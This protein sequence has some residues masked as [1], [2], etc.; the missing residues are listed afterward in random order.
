MTSFDKMVAG[1]DGDLEMVVAGEPEESYLLD[2]ITPEDGEA[3]MPKKKEPLAASELELIRTWISQGAVDDTPAGAVLRYDMKHPP[4]Y[5]LPPVITSVDYSP[6]G[7]L[8]AVAGFNEVLLHQADGSAMVARL[9]GMSQRI[10]SVRFSPDGKSLAV[11]GG[12]PAR[13]G[14][15]QVW[16]VDRRKLRLS[17]P[18]GYD[19]VYGASWSP[20]G[21][22][23][24]FG[25]PDN[26]LRAINAKTGK[27]VLYQGSH[28]DWPLDTVFSAA[29]THVISASRDRTAKL[30]EL[31]TQRFIDN[32]TSITPGALSGGLTSVA[33]HPVKDEIL[34]GGADGVPKLFRVFRTSKRVIG[35]DANLIRKF[36]P[37]TGRVFAV[38][39][40]RDG[41]QI[42]AGSSYNGS[43]QV[44]V[45]AY[46]FDGKL[47]KEIEAILGKRATDRSEKEQQQLAEYH[48]KDVKLLAEAEI[49]Q[50]G[51]YAIAFAPDGKTVAAAG[52][53]GKVRLLDAENGALLNAFVP[54]PVDAMQTADADAHPTRPPA[55][56]QDAFEHRSLHAEDKLVSLEVEPA[57]ATIDHKYDVAQLIVT[58]RLESGDL[59]DVTRLVAV[60]VSTD[61]VEVSPRGLAC[62][63]SNGR[64]ELTFSLGG[65]S[66]RATIEVAGVDADA[67][68]DY[69][70]D[71]M[72]VFG[73][74]GCN[75][76]TCHGSKKGKGGLKTSLRGNDPVY[77]IRAFVDDLASRRVNVASAA[78][79]LMLLKAT[80]SVPHEGGQVLRPPDPYYEVIRQWIADGARI[81]TSTPKVA[82]IEIFPKNR[83]MQRT[84][85]QQQFRVVATYADGRVRDVTAEAFI[86]SGD[87]EVAT[88]DSAGLLSAMRRG[89]V[90][91]LARYQGSYAATTLTV[92]GD[93]AG[94]VW[95]DPPAN[96]YV[97]ELVA[98]KLKR[99]KT[100]PSELCT[101]AE[102]IRRVYLDLAGLPPTADQVREFLADERDS[103]T[104]RDELI[105]RLIGCDDYIEH[106]TNRWADLMQVNRKYLGAE[107]AKA[108]RG[109]IR[110][111]V[112]DNTPY[113]RF[114]YKL[115]TASGSNRENPA[116]SY[117]KI[118]RTPEDTM[119]NST[120]LFLG[121]RFSCNKC[122]DHPFERWVQNN[123]WETAAYFARVG[124][125]KDPAGGDKQIGKT[126]VE[127][128]K[129]LYE[130]V[131]D[132]EQGEVIHDATG[133]ATPPK[134][135]YEVK[136]D[137][138]ENASRREQIARWMTAPDNRYFAKS[139]ANRVWGYLLGKGFIEPLDDIR[140]GNPPT[141]AELLD[142][143]TEDFIAG[144]FD[145]RR[146]I[147][148]ICQSRTY[149][150]SI[151]A[152]RWNEDDTIN[153]SHALARRLPA[154][155]LYDALHRVT[156]SV[157][158]I[159][160]V[161][162]GTRAAALPDAG[163]KDSDGFLETFGRPP[164]ESACECERATGMQF[165]P[166]MALVTGPTVGNVIS[167]PES[168]IS[169]L[170]A[171]VE[172][173]ARLIDELFMRILSRPASEAE[174]EVGV[175][176]IRG[177]PA[178]HEQLLAEL[179]EYEKS[180]APEIAA[181]EQQ[182]LATIA[183]AKETLAAYEKELAP[184]NAELDRLQK[185][186]TARLAAALQT[187][188]ETLPAKLAAWQQRQERSIA[189]V[190][191]DPVELSATNSA[192][193]TKEAD[194]S[195][196]ATGNSGKG[197]YR[198]V[199]RS[200][201]T[202]ITGV[203]LELFAD[204]RLP[205]NGPGRAPN[206]NFVVS[207]FRMDAAP[208]AMLEE[209]E[210]VELQ[211]PQADFSQANYEV[212][213]TI[214]RSVDPVNDG[215][216]T[217]PKV[218]EN[219]TAVFETTQDVGFA[220]GT[221]LGFWLDQL[222]QDGQHS[223]GRFRISVTTAPRPV[224]LDGLP[225]NITA[226][227]AVAA[228]K[229]ND[230]QKAE[231]MKYFRG[232]DAELK[233]HQQAVAESKKP[234][235][236]DS[237]LKQLREAPQV[238]NRAL[239]ADPKL[240]QLRRDVELSGKQLANPRLTGAQDLAWAL[241]NSSAFLFNR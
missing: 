232:S 33:R 56:R 34:V 107:G 27:Q 103:R 171:T 180:L 58:G 111:E 144:G 137:V 183:K 113:D 35:D 125:K 135:P 236:I 21:K 207:E 83:I 128:G 64:A 240:E 19:T 22:L 148:T 99:T 231:L 66:A 170:V 60:D 42:A 159:P 108:F 141:N 48:T 238:A 166:V 136:F 208:K 8:L 215:W 112:A 191:L 26:T 142:R 82:S 91:V 14:E 190:A 117:F 54:V 41:K 96:N 74:A 102:F 126:A 213:K 46:D 174:I 28:N 176:V 147:R 175:A 89:E 84:D 59:V 52:S 199:A 110:G 55:R 57:E 220:G 97:D 206:G 227:L 25:C 156:G 30:T 132:R 90:P 177:M 181:R 16:D 115:L 214:N 201:L 154:E 196:L 182:R 119:E 39:I 17:V 53:D 67:K 73:K 124:L 219:R 9:V 157:S 145:V 230:Q 36:P 210:L 146:L 23:I 127:Q 7:K 134:F 221:E 186:K 226:V 163:V 87:I 118:L 138:P 37:L 77:E 143:L 139:Y 101:D 235:P 5:S 218:G 18:V 68:V 3:E 10:E 47:P 160:G 121:V 178:E 86:S 202:G 6:D 203:R 229:R 179:K 158:K 72:P 131:F 95:K 192:K 43:G 98:V 129:P 204:K 241:I 81:D 224:R 155:V 239:P 233:K 234:R 116:A 168:E 187:Y 153:Y 161:A 70:R 40:S 211:N 198:F 29:G 93:R 4:V 228:D 169:K 114:A 140:A 76:G 189:W 65:Q 15:V 195:V 13:M 209:V 79:S 165:G 24:A 11:T 2:V 225:E 188:E 31:A 212:A 164:R 78:N 32:I 217:S 173:D 109:W 151:A 106:W 69:I 200:D 49:D 162:P 88:A 123:Y 92:M 237:K 205:G 172:D 105:D 12:L 122:H 94:F 20:D 44:R 150:M 167:D 80:A 75:A 184:K 38:A 1:P 85:G 63:K 216:A 133:E 193:L 62:P 152:N 45:Y 100:A 51:V 194:L 223:V 104:K 71:V 149:Q 130:I 50:G 61:V 120:H 222:Y 185:E 197:S